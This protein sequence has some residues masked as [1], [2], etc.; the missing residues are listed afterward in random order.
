MRKFWATLT[1]ALALG[2][3]WAVRGHFGHEH[4]A[5]WAGAVGA[6]A[7]VAA[8][9]RRD[10]IARLP[11]AAAIGGIGWGIGGMMSYGIVVG[12]CRGTDF[13]NVLYGFAMLSI[14]GGLYGYM[15]GGLLGLALETTEEKSP[16]WPRLTTETVAFGLLAWGFLIYQLE[17]KMTPPRSELWAAS[18]GA[19][20]ALGWFLQRNGF[21]R[22]MR[23]AW[24]SSVGA[25]FGFAFGNFLQI[26]GN[27]TGLY[28]NWWN[29]MEF[30]LGFCGG[31]G[32]A[33]G[34]FG[35]EWPRAGSPGRASLVWAILLL[36]VGVP[37]VN[38]VQAFDVAPFE[39]LARAVGAAD[40]RSF[41]LT[42]I[43]LAVA[44]FVI[45]LGYGWFL[46]RGPKRATP[47][48]FSSLALLG[49]AAYYIVMGDLKKGFFY[50]PLRGQP[51]QLIYWL[52]LALSL[53]SLWLGKKADEP[54]FGNRPLA[55][56]HYVIGLALV[57][58]AA[59][60]WASISVSLHEGLPGAHERF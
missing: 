22:A 47:E 14:I 9:G 26:L 37:V 12:Y 59:L 38:L 60:V 4:G 49:Y 48:R 21:E 19:A 54:L 28:F 31:V 25:G 46:W 36:V 5:A 7:V 34:I 51:E 3:A 13:A 24:F 35:V 56:R 1:V 39:E 58:V 30:T 6:L 43:G 18:L 23:A 16:D 44:L 20:V 33:V 55:G 32:M 41:A 17:W 15:G 45:F 29:V 11:I 50:L 52:L 2:L 40:P 53:G 10:W 8:S 57:L 42:Q 27:L